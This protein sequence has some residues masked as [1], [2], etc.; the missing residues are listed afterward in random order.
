MLVSGYLRAKKKYFKKYYC[1]WPL[2]NKF[3][4]LMTTKS[5]NVKKNISKFVYFAMKLRNT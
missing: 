3:D 5:T 4:V 1:H 2:L